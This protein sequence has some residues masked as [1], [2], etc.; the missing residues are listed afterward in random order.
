MAAAGADRP[1]TVTAVSI[2]RQH[3][4]AG[5]R[6]SALSV[7]RS[8]SSN[9]LIGERIVVRAYRPSDAPAVW[10]G[11]EESRAS[12]AR[13]IPDLARR[14]TQA[15][16]LSGIEQLCTAR[17]RGERL[18]YGIWQR[19]DGEF[20]GEVGLHDVNV[21]RRAAAVGYWLRTSAR[22][23]GLID[24]ALNLLHSYA[25]GE[26]GLRQLEAHIASENAASRRVAE[27]LGYLLVGQRPT[28][29]LWDGEAATMLIYSLIFRKTA[30]D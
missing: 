8:T 27:R 25:V 19:S 12:L 11:I 16:V 4:G 7:P 29:P 14:R 17:A 3:E 24:E 26:L 9:D 28:D 1:G 13:W 30:G 22:G 2:E 20:L 6:D 10:H 15:E 5:S 21:P 23:Q 18:L